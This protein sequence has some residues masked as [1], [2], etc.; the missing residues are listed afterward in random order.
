M[1]ITANDPPLPLERQ[2]AIASAIC[3]WNA[4]GRAF[5]QKHQALYDALPEGLTVFHVPVGETPAQDRPVCAWTYRK[6]T[7]GSI[8]EGAGLLVILPSRSDQPATEELPR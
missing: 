5:R 7:D 8:Q 2:Y 3:E 6:G 4:A 1:T